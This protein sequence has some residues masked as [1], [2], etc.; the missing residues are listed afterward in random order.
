MAVVIYRGSTPT[1]YISPTNGMQVSDLGEP[2]IAISQDIAFLTPDV[3][4]DTANNRL[5]VTLT[6]DDTLS[7]TEGVETYLQ[8]VYEVGDGTIIRFPMHPVTVVGTLMEEVTT[9]QEEE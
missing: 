9:T 7:L 1:I 2:T 3:T 6:E 8:A 4:V 5:V